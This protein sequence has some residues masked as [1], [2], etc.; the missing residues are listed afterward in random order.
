[1][2]EINSSETPIIC[3]RCYR[4]KLCPDNGVICYSCFY[5]LCKSWKNQKKKMKN[6]PKYNSI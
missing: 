4:Y 5:K 3:H 1:M 2:K 6:P